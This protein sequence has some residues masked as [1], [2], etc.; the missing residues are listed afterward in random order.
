MAFNHMEL[1][2]RNLGGLKIDLF[3]KC[4]C[5]VIN[6]AALPAAHYSLIII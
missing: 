5:S 6:P 1:V 4:D 3:S 2:D